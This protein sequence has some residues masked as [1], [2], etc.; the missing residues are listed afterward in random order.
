[1]KIYTFDFFYGEEKT[2]REIEIAAASYAEAAKAAS[3]RAAKANKAYSLKGCNRIMIGSG[4]LV[5]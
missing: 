1:M 3:K 4:R 5:K 2:I